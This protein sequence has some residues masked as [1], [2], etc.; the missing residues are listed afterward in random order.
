M[1]ERTARTTG[2]RIIT[3]QGAIGIVIRIKIDGSSRRDQNCDTDRPQRSDRVNFEQARD[4]VGSQDSSNWSSQ[5][6]YSDVSCS[7]KV[8]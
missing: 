5:Y 2:G 7:S 6:S 3:Y 4:S 8:F 1:P